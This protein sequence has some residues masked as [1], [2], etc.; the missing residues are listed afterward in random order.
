MNKFKGLLCVGLAVIVCLSM[1]GC[2]NTNRQPEPSPEITVDPTAAPGTTDGPG[3]L[4][5]PTNAPVVPKFDWVVNGKTVEDQ[6]NK[7]SEISAS[8]VIVTGETALVGIQFASE[9]KGELTDRIRE[10]VAA[11]VKGADGNVQKVAVTA[12]ANDVATINDIA[13]KIQNGAP[14]TDFEQ[15][16]DS[17]IRNVTTT[18]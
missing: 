13:D 5:Q 15:E 4:N 7:I 8:R 17:I 18:S 16:I 2:M 14:A 11:E 12:E 1:A 10:M 9:Y 6:I 3:L